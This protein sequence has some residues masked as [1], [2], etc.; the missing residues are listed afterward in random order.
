MSDVNCVES[1][2]LIRILSEASTVICAL[3]ALTLKPLP[4]S[5]PEPLVLI[6]LGS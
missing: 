1:F 2:A 3:L 4:P 5:V 6:S